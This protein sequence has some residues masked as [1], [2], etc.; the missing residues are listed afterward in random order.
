MGGV[1][2]PLR[3]NVYLHRYIEAFRRAGF[4]ERYGAVL[5]NYADDFVVLCRREASAVL[6][7]TRRKMA[8]IGLAL[9]EAKTCVRDARRESFQFLGYTFG[10]MYWPRNGRRYLGAAPSRKA[11][12][13]AKGHVRGLLS[14]GNQAPWEEV[15]ERLNRLLQGWANYFCYGTLTKARREVQRYV[16]DRVRSFLRRRRHGAARESR[17]Y[18]EARVFG[19]MGVL[20]LWR[21]P[22]VGYAN[23]LS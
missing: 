15:R 17:R 14:P 2:S 19:E 20:S 11:I 16:W 6:E 5:V 3:A 12:T 21:C 23:A 18:S 4:G 1:A 7:A 9:N 22:R 10:P 13:Q 8:E